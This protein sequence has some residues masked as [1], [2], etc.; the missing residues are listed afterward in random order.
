MTA[1]RRGL[2]LVVLL[3]FALLGGC[4][5][6]WLGPAERTARAAL[7][8]WDMWSTPSVRPYEAPMPHG[9]EGTVPAHPNRSLVA[10]KRFEELT[11]EERDAQGRLAYRRFCHHC[12]GVNGDGRTVVG[13]SFDVRPPDLR[14]DEIQK[15]DDATLA[16]G[17]AS[18]KGAV[19]PLGPSMTELEIR[20]AI[21]HMRSLKNNRSTPFY[22]RRSIEPTR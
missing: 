20:L 7:M 18:G 8:G 21:H 22:P 4:K 17:V 13:E 9:V 19:L 11:P 12:H 6:D 10:E 1:P 14:A 5:G 15:R 2:Y 3:A 16:A